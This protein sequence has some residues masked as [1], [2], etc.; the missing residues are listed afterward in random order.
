MDCHIY[1]NTL[2]KNK[3]LHFIKKANIVKDG[4]VKATNKRRNDGVPYLAGT[5]FKNKT[6]ILPNRLIL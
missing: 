5:L 2:L 4:V 6:F 3:T 1:L